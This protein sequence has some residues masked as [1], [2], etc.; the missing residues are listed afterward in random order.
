MF[1]QIFLSRQ[2]KGSAIIT[3]KYDLYVASQV[4]ERLKIWDFRKLGK[5]RIIS[6]INFRLFKFFDLLKLSLKN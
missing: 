1:H 2:V 4:A 6:K 3:Y 5:V